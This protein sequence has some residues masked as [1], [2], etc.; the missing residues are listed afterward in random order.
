MTWEMVAAIAQVIVALAVVPSLIYVAI[1]LRQQNLES[2]RAAATVF[3]LNW[4]DFRKSLSD[5]ADLAAIHLRGIE[6]FDSLNSVEKLR[7]GTVLGRIMVLGEE[8]YFFYL[9]GALAPDL[10]RDLRTN[11]RGSHCVPP[12]RKRGGRPAGTGTR[13]GSALIDG[14][15]RAEDQANDLRSLHTA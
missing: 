5:H 9:E 1:Q 8:L 12:G 2:R 6:S 14:H 15:D 7:F 13:P 4:T 10:W 3:M 11:D